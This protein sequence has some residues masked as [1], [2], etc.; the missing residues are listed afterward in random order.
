MKGQYPIAGKVEPTEH[1]L[2]KPEH[3]QAAGIKP[4]NAY[5][6]K[7]A[8]GTIL[9]QSAEPIEQEKKI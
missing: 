4:G 7:T 3:L 1:I 2:I 5:T 9:I 8:N 6:I